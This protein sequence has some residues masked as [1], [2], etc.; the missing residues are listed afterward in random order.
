VLGKKIDFLI[1]QSIIIGM[2]SLGM[3][4]VYNSYMGDKDSS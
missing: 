4:L 3:G 2:L 1:I